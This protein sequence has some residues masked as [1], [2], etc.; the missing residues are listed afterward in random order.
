MVNEDWGFK[1]KELNQRVTV[2]EKIV[3]NISNYPK[4][5]EKDWDTSTLIQEWKISKR[6][7][8]NYRQRGMKYYRRGGR[9]FYTPESRNEFIETTAS[10]LNISPSR[11]MSSET[12]NDVINN[13]NKEKTYGK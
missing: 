9:L 4:L 7:A 6:T 13:K 12:M 8:A 11:S 5:S 2:I 1:L 10:S 3:E